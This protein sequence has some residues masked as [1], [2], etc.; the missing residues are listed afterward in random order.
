MIKLDFFTKKWFP[1]NLI[2][3]FS[4]FIIAYRNYNMGR[5]SLNGDLYLKK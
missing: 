4:C 1:T 5:V 3:V 2:I